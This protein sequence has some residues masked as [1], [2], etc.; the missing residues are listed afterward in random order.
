[1]SPGIDQGDCH[2]LGWSGRNNAL[3]HDITQRDDSDDQDVHAGR[4]EGA[5][6]LLV[7]KTPNVF[8]WLG[9]GFEFERRQLLGEEE[10]VKSAEERLIQRLFEGLIRQEQVQFRL[11]AGT[12]RVDLFGSHNSRLDVF[13]ACPEDLNTLKP[14]SYTDEREPSQVA[15]ITARFFVK[16]GTD[17]PTPTWVGLLPAS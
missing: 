13:A 8:Y 6:L 7:V 4:A 17:H 3:A 9:F 2:L 1:M 16:S 15:R 5:I 14:A 12:I 10:L 11:A